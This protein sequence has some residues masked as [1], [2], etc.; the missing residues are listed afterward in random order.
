MCIH[1]AS[2][3]PSLACLPNK[4]LKLNKKVLKIKRSSIKQLSS[5]LHKLCNQLDNQIVNEGKLFFT[6]AFQVKRNIL[7]IYHTLQ[8]LINYYSKVEEQIAS[9]KKSDTLEFFQVGGKLHA[10]LVLNI[11]HEFSEGLLIQMD[12]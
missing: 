9:N 4:C 7:T 6:E 11:F 12:F 3:S 2:I 5:S 1:S 8:P 10:L